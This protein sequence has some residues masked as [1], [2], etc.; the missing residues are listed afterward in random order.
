MA[1]NLLFIG[2]PSILLYSNSIKN[3]FKIL[4]FNVFEP[5]YIK[6]KDQNRIKKIFFRKSFLTN[7]FH[8][9]NIAYIEA[10]KNFHPDYIF[11]INNSRINEE[12]LQYCNHKNLPIFMYCIDSIK[13]CDKALEYMHYYDEIFSYEPSDASIEFKPN[14]FIKFIPLGADGEIYRPTN[15][16]NKKYDLCFVGRLDNHRLNILESVAKYVYKNNLEFIVFT[17]IQLFHIPSIWLLPKIFIRRLKYNYKYP[18]LMKYIVNRP[19]IGKELVDLYNN[20]K[21]CLNIH[22]ATHPGMHTGP[23]P[24]TFELLACKT[25]EIIDYGHINKTKLKSS[26]DLIEFKTANDLI[27]K[28]DFYLK[29]SELREKISNQGYMA[30]KQNYELI[31]SVK[32]IIKFIK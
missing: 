21:I 9:Q 6:F 27:K 10:A 8:R 5:E 25:F 7:F 22:V 19:I 26:V 24:R 1:K 14:K 11:V 4:G 31:N 3:C 32:E 29:N 13:W 18:Y 30:C 2:T 15:I 17:S 20:T 28:I 12:F 16:I 23:N